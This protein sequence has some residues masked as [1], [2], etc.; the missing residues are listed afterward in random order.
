MFN[1][2]KNNI[3]LC[4]IL[5]LLMNNSLFSNEKE[6]LLGKDFKYQNGK[7]ISLKD[8]AIYKSNYITDE[9]VE[10][11]ER[12]FNIKSFKHLNEGLSI[13][14]KQPAANVVIAVICETKYIRI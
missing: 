1:L 11:D 13:L 3:N 8:K 6:I 10:V 7:F 12:F 4:L 5:F 2:N 9:I 14:M